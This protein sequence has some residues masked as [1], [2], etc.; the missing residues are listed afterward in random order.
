M[1]SD[2]ENRTRE[3]PAGK[4]PADE[5]DEPEEGTFLT[6][7]GGGTTCEDDSE[8]ADA[9]IV[10]DDLCAEQQ[11]QQISGSSGQVSAEEDEALLSAEEEEEPAGGEKNSAGVP[12]ASQSA[13]EDE[14]LIPADLDTS[15]GAHLSLAHIHA[16]IDHVRRCIAGFA[17]KAKFPV[18]N[19]SKNISDNCSSTVPGSPQQCSRNHDDPG[20]C[21][22]SP[23]SPG[24]GDSKTKTKNAA[25]ARPAADEKT[26]ADASRRENQQKPNQPGLTAHVHVGTQE[27][28]VRCGDGCQDV[29]WLVQVALL[30]VQEA[31]V[32]D[33]W[34]AAGDGGGGGT[35]CPRPLA[36]RGGAY[37]HA[38]QHVVQ[39]SASSS[40]GC[41]TKISGGPGVGCGLAG[42]VISSFGSTGSNN[43]SGSS[44]GAF[45]TRA[46]TGVTAA[47]GSQIG[48][49]ENIARRLGDPSGLNQDFHVWLTLQRI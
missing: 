24:S 28:L 41:S 22:S 5:P 6:A 17:G 47:D 4:Q 48:L 16:K 34:W 49:R 18:E 32:R 35:S 44:V 38:C 43:F 29:A 33:A 3:A 23:G 10:V 8:E 40:T 30:Q 27:F 39:S 20:S 13:Q 21:L 36:Q 11:I 1:T 37:P 9:H 25:T 26:T 45:H 12:P 15:V 19:I 14:L 42:G 7:L 31:E 2:E 46:V